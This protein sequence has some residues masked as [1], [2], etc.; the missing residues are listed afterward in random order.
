M[1]PHS[2]VLAAALLMLT[3]AQAGEPKLEPIALQSGVSTPPA[4]KVN[5]QTQALVQERLQPSTPE[6]LI[7]KHGSLGA[8]FARPGKV[9]AL[10]FFN[11][12]APVEYGGPGRASAVWS[13]NPMLAPGQGPLPRVFQD[14]RT[15]EP[16]GVLFGWG[17]R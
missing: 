14:N 2:R 17:A 7:E 1:N 9:N 10:Q 12:L 4:A 16:S 8:I 13:W 5:R 3:L 15:H 6:K 11:P